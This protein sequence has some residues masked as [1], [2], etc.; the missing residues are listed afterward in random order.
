MASIVIFCKTLVK[1]GAEKQALTLA[2]LLAHRSLDVV[3][4][5]WSRKKTDTHNRKFIDD[6]SLKYY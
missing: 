1:G 3:V 4:I 2:R 5:S 6:N